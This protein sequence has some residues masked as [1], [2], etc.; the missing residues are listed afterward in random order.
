MKTAGD[1]RTDREDIGQRRKE[2]NKDETAGKKRDYNLE[3]I[4]MCSFMM[5]IA[6]HVSN[7]FCRAYG[8]ITDSEYVFSLIIDTLARVSVPAS[9]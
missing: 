4:R 5:V 7:Y 8:Q 6:I 1:R 3:L 9:L 2:W